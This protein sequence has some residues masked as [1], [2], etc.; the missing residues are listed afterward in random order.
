M[1]AFVVLADLIILFG[2]DNAWVVVFSIELA[3][4]S[5]LNNAL[6]IFEFS[7]VALRVDLRSATLRLIYII[8]VTHDLGLFLGTGTTHSQSDHILCPLRG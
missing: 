8:H 1:I 6:F 2:G 7:T 3:W 4:D 5:H